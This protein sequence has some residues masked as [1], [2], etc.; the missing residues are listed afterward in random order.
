MIGDVMGTPKSKAPT[1]MNH[2]DGEKRVAND[3]KNRFQS[4]ST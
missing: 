4:S 3:F 2:M 1:L